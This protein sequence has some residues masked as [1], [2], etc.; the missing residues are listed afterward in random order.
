MP[1][2]TFLVEDSPLIRQTLMPAMEELVGAQF[3]GSAT[4]EDAA[5]AWLEAH[6]DDWQ[7]AVVD[8]FL[9]QGTGLGV[10][11]QCR[12]RGKNQLCTSSR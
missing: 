11:R 8:L 2:S 1:L 6:P 5:I 7:L 9:E 10:V 12:H 3:I 4:R